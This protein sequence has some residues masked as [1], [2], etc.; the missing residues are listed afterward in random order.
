MV[1]T[2][3]LV[4][5]LT[6]ATPGRRPLAQFVIATPSDGALR[7]GGIH[8]EVAISPDGTR[9]AY[10]AGASTQDRQLYL[11]HLGQLAARPLRGTEGGSG[12]VFSPDGEWVGFLSSEHT[13]RKVSVRGGTAVTIHEA[14]SPVRGLSWGPDDAIVFG[15]PRGLMRVPAGGGQPEPLTTVDQERGETAHIWPDVLPSRRS[16]LFTAWSGS[17]ER[18]RLAVVSLETGE[19]SY[20]LPGGSHPRY[21]ATGHI[22][23]G[24]GGTLWAVG[25]D[26][27]RQELTD[28]NPVPVVEH[29]NTK[30]VSGAASFGLSYDGSLVYLAGGMTDG[31]PQRS[32]SWVDR[33]GRESP[34]E[35]P[36]RGYDWPRLSPDGTRLALNVLDPENTDV[37]ILDIGRETTTRLTFDTAHDLRPVWTP[38]G[39]RVI[40]ASQR[41]G[42]AQLFGKAADGTGA[43][44]RL[45]QSEHE[46]VPQA[47]SP[48]GR[49]LVAQ[50][51]SSDTGTD[52]VL[53]S[54]DDDEATVPLLATEFT[55]GN[56]EISPDGQWIAYQAIP[57]GRFEVYVQPFPDLDEGKWMV[58]A[59]GGTRPLW[60]P[61]GREL[62]FLDPDGRL[63]VV[64]MDTDD[65]VRPG[66]PEVLTHDLFLPAGPGRNY[67]IAPDGQRFLVIRE[68]RLADTPST[69]PRVVL[70][71]NWL[72]E[73]QRLT[74]PPRR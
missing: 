45:T 23:Y 74:S 42:P 71:Q 62:F 66:I 34:L 38:D 19:V 41:G 63:M 69:A 10:G 25:F 60:A 61:D 27:D 24:A 64:A 21:A 28:R 47:V 26:P 13:L 40:F 22:V 68:G 58:S 5:S 65:G 49:L 44:E 43:V 9:I 52:L 39:R 20:L 46:L 73:L 11:R 15:S 35:L 18:S 33:E 53:L 3:I 8:P 55:E 16:V 51:R 12:P 6:E 37:W 7:T 56:A 2:G 32:L 36:S 70:V 54:L 67:D 57:S 4:W 30:A 31:I 59:D 17:T 14:G 48:D 29:V 50:E 72:R 1:L